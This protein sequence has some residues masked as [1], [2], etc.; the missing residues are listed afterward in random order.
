MVIYVYA[1]EEIQGLHGI[2]DENVFEVEDDISKEELQ[3]LIDDWGDEMSDELISSYGLEGEYL[4]ELD[5]YD[6]DDYDLRECPSYCDRGW[7]A[8]KVKNEYA[9]DALNGRYLNEGHNLF[10]Q[11]YCEGDLLNEE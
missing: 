11:N 4:E 7:V 8:Y 5:D 6:E 9:K 10:I 1:W 2:E 3:K